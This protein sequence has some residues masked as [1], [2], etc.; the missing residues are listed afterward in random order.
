[1]TYAVAVTTPAPPE[2]DVTTPAPE[3]DVTTPAPPEVDVFTPGPQGPPGPPGSISGPAGGDLGGTYPNPFVAQM[4]QASVAVLG[5]QSVNYGTLGGQVISDVVQSFKFSTDAYPRVLRLADGR[6]QRYSGLSPA[7]WGVHNATAGAGS[8]FQW[9]FEWS[10]NT[11]IGMHFQYP[12][13]H[14]TDG[15]RWLYL[16]MPPTGGWPLAPGTTLQ[17]TSTA[18]LAASGT[19]QIYHALMGAGTVTYTSITDATHLVCSG[20]TGFVSPTDTSAV[21]MWFVRDSYDAPILWLGNYGGLHV[22]DQ[23]TFQATGVFSSASWDIILGFDQNSRTGT[24][25]SSLKF[26]SDGAMKIYRGDDG[27]GNSR[28]FV[29]AAG[30]TGSN[31]LVWST[32]G[33]YPDA[34][35]NLGANTAYWG[36][37]YL[38]SIH[39]YGNDTTS[40]IN[41]GTDAA[42]SIN[43]DNDGL[44]DSRLVFTANGAHANGL[45]LSEAG[46]YPTTTQTAGLN[47]GQGTSNYWNH[48]FITDVNL[49]ND[50]T[51]AIIKFGQDGST[52]IN[53]DND[54]LGNARIVFNAGGTGGAHTMLYSAGGLYT[55]N[56]ENLGAAAAPWGTTWSRWFQ[57]ATNGTA[58]APAYSFQA[59]TDSGLYLAAT[60]PNTVALSA[61]GTQVLTA[62]S[63]GV[64]IVLGNN[65]IGQ[66]VAPVAAN[67]VA[68]NYAAQPVGTAAWLRADATS[69][70]CPQITLPNDGLTYRVTLTA[71]YWRV[72]TS[73]DSCGVGIGDIATNTILGHV[74]SISINNV[75]NPL[76]PVF[77]DVVGTGQTLGVYVEN[78]NGS[79][80]AHVITIGCGALGS[81][82][83]PSTLTATRVA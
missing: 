10:Q 11:A 56:F 19:L 5:R 74:G 32:A 62:T 73:G 63:A 28:L 36:A 51:A 83:A 13:F 45:I 54:G 43:R 41:F 31:L 75:A 47:L 53:R 8:D 78:A 6:F 55:G 48:L 7:S 21:W 29:Q 80:A 61:G 59:A 24:P 82:N 1:V 30:T 44:G 69:G 57:A 72:Q 18:G 81:A 35:Q 58:A 27:F 37:S 49:K 14:M 4:T 68:G 52:A 22:N 64:R 15:T 67:S 46:L 2:V 76:P 17:V 39:L 77:A 23:Y 26:G 79:G 33:L 70:T 16:E 66:R 50:T 38:H 34:G 71:G 12:R 42:A 3:V 60:G 65:T 20:S 25:L 40:F 9:A